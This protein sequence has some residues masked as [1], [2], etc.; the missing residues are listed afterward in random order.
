MLISFLIIFL[1]NGVQSIKD[2]CYFILYINFRNKFC[3]LQMKDVSDLDSW[4][5]HFSVQLDHILRD[6]A[7]LR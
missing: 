2:H 4:K 1:R 3:A 7:V 6:N 5:S